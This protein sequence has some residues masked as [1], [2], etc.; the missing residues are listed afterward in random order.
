MSLLLFTISLSAQYFSD[1]GEWQ[2]KIPAEYDI[3]ADKINE[4]VEI[5][6]ETRIIY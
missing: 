3:Y 6:T 5:A 2:H 1:K 4:A